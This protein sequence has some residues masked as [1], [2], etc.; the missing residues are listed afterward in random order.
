MQERSGLYRHQNLRRLSTVLATRCHRR[1]HTGQKSERER[2]RTRKRGSCVVT[3][4]SIFHLFFLPL[5]FD[6]FCS[7]SVGILP[8][9]VLFGADSLVP[10][11]SFGALRMR[12]VAVIAILCALAVIVSA[13]LPPSLSALPLVECELTCGG[14]WRGLIAGPGETRQS[15]V[16]R[17]AGR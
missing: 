1:L 9:N 11:L 6:F 5:F 17:F 8:L 16:P 13:V 14:V 4:T 2:E 10:P 3:I 15:P 12:A 7:F